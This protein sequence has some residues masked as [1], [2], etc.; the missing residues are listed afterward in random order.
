MTK[1]FRHAPVEIEKVKM[2]DAKRKGDYIRLRKWFGRKADA[3]AAG[4][5]KG[6]IS[7]MFVGVTEV[8]TSF[9]FHKASARCRVVPC[10]F[11]NV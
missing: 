8:S 2:N 6:I 4:S 11:A 7:S 1:N 9:F 3:A 10:D 5:I